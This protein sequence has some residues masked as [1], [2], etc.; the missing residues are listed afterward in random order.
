MRI[1]VLGTGMVGRTL[2]AKLV[3]LGH[4]VKLGSRSADNAKAGEWVKSIG[5]AASQGTFADAASFGE[6]VFNCTAGGASLDALNLAGALHLQGKTLV[7]VANPLDFSHGTPPTLSICN[8]ES[9]GERIQTAFPAAKVVKTLNTV[10]A[11]VMV[12]PSLVPGDH[13]VFISGNEAVAKAQVIAILKDFGW[14]H[15]VDLGDITTAVGA[16]MWLP[17]W[18]RLWGAFKTPN[19]NI[20]V[21][22]A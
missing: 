18:L 11:N 15:I 10:N 21:T 9:L 12:N 6:I 8:T 20:H 7:D 17:M 22:H 2:G 5:R 4:D 1:A 13:D 3:E 16:E 19:I 14:R